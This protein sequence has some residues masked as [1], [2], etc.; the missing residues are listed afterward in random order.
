MIL[1]IMHQPHLHQPWRLDRCNPFIHPALAQLQCHVIV[2]C[3]TSQYHTCLRPLNS[4]EFFSISFLCLSS[5]LQR[6]KWC[7]N[8]YDPGHHLPIGLIR[9]QSVS[10]LRRSTESMAPFEQQPQKKQDGILWKLS[11]IVKHYEYHLFNGSISKP[12]SPPHE[13]LIQNVG[14][15]EH[16]WKLISNTISEALACKQEPENGQLAIF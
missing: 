1:L 14:R 13:W 11:S 15:S 12:L 7:C 16:Q 9:P 2:G 5:R 6:C 10:L 4:V 8:S 3:C